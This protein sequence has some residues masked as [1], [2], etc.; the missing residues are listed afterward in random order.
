MHYELSIVARA[1]VD[2]NVTMTMALPARTGWHAH[3]IEDFP[4][5]TNQDAQLLERL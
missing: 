2:G 3:H 1:I 5:Q 4:I